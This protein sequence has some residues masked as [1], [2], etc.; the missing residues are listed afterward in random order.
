MSTQ[1]SSSNHSLMVPVRRTTTTEGPL[2]ARRPATR[3]STSYTSPPLNI[4]SHTSTENL[5]STPSSRMSHSAS[6]SR[7]APPPPVPTS[8]LSNT[9]S[10]SSNIPSYRFAGIPTGTPSV[11]PVSF[12]SSNT[13]SESSFS[14][15]TRKLSFRS[16][17]SSQILSTKHKDVPTPSSTPKEKPSKNFVMYGSQL[18]DVGHSDT[19]GRR[20][21]MEDACVSYGEFAGIGTQYYAIFDGHGGPEVSSYCAANLHQLISDYYENGNSFVAAT[22]KAIQDVNSYVVDKWPQAGSTAA[23]AIIDDDVLYTANVGDSRIILVHKGKAKRLSVDHKAVS[24]DEMECILRRGGT[25]QSNRVN[26]ILML[27]RAIGDGTVARYISSEPFMTQ[28]IL[29][30]NARLILAC[31][32]VWDVMDDQSAADIFLQIKNPEEAAKAIKSEAIK[33][34]TMDNVSVICVDLNVNK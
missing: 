32:G 7:R 16:A 1:R 11:A 30:D 6:F 24:P 25:I 19:I 9:N 5:P 18:F 10:S 22:K 17:N 8:N 3:Y 13:R 23:I 4:S 27:S 28:T 2:S 29:K 12:N 31:D 20:A 15:S 34:G 21:S 33:R 14:T 26:G